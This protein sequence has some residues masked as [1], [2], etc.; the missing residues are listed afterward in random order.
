MMKPP[1][2]KMSAEGRKSECEE[3]YRGRGSKR[4]YPSVRENTSQTTNQVTYG[5]G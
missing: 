2:G 3:R 1:E 5:Q 4:T